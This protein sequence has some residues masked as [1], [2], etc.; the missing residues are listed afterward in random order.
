MARTFDTPDS[1]AQPGV[2]KASG[3][4]TPWHTP[5]FIVMDVG[6]T[7]TMCHSSTDGGPMASGS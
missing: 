6:E 7:D 2:A 5:K 3:V 4:G 1:D